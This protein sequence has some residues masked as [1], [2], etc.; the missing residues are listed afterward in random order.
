MA[1][2]ILIGDVGGHPDQLRAA[3]AGAGAYPRVPDGTTVVQVGDLVDRGPDSPGVLE[4]VEGYLRDQPHRWIQLIGNH[5]AQYLPGRSMFYPASIEGAQVDTLRSF[6]MHLA[7]AVST[8]TDD[9]LVTHAGLI[10]G[11]WRQIGEPMTASTAAM[12][13]NDRPDLIGHAQGPLWAEAGTDLYEAWLDFRDF[14]PFGQI[15]GHSSIVSFKDRR[16]HCAEKVRQRATVDWQA[17]HTRVRIGGRQFIG[18]DPKLGKT[19]AV[20]WS[21]LILDG[22]VFV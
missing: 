11:I 4:I 20:P 21:P 14:V 9:Y 13:L 17:R 15:H 3:L 16:F 7:A 22:E 2:V 18:V 10:P 5:D 6:K 19:G 8:P 1:R 12:L